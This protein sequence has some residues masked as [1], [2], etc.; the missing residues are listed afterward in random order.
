MGNWTH[1]LWPSFSTYRE[2]YLAK[3]QDTALNQP[4]AGLKQTGFIGSI[5]PPNV[6]T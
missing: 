6:L 5:P 2:N 1:F 3:K 4:P